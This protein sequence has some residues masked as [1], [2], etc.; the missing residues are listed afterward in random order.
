MDAIIGRYRMS[1]EETGLVLKHQAGISF[2]LT[3]EETLGLRD[4]I[5]LYHQTLMDLQEEKIDRQ[6]EPD[7]KAIVLNKEDS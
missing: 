1:M 6:T 3:V 7:I 2:D 4:F 5:N